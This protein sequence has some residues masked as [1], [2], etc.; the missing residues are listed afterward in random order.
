MKTIRMI[1]ALSM[2]AF[3]NVEA[4][5]QLLYAQ[6]NKAEA[7]SGSVEQLKKAIRDGKTI[8]IYMNL[9]FVEHLMD[10][11]FIS[12]IGGNVYAQISDIQAQKPNRKT[13]E[14]TLRPYAKHVG[15]YST[16]SPY[17]IKWYAVD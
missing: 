16:Q 11:G 15:L 14:I 1:A 5:P 9:G 10:A 2:L 12:I 17:E 4:A 8:R 6:D 7:V 13:S 3:G